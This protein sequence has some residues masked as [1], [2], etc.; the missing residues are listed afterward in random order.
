MAVIRTLKAFPSNPPRY[1]QAD[2]S[3]YLFLW[4]YQLADGAIDL[5]PEVFIRQI[6]IH[7]LGIGSVFWPRNEVQSSRVVFPWA[8]PTW[9]LVANTVAARK[10]PLGWKRLYQFKEWGCT[11]VKPRTP[12]S[13]Y[14]VQEIPES[15]RRSATPNPL[16]LPRWKRKLS[17][18]KPIQETPRPLVPPTPR[19]E[20]EPTTGS[21]S[22]NKSTQSRT[23]LDVKKTRC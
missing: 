8:L 18:S 21:P 20:F 15:S 19:L 23:D 4:T 6:E 1:P 9:G 2:E 3:V 5:L 12:S 22:S 7:I 16:P 14:T 17:S 13:V 11:L 10:C